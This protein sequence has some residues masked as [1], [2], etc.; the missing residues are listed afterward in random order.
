MT[1]DQTARMLSRIVRQE[2][3]WKWNGAHTGAAYAAFCVSGRT[4]GAHR[5]VYEYY[6]APIPAGLHLDHLCRNRWCVNPTHLE[7]VTSGENTRRSPLMGKQQRGHRPGG[8]NGNGLK[9]ECVRGHRFTPE[10][11]IARRNGGRWCRQCEQIRSSRRNR[12]QASALELLDRMIAV[13]H[14]TLSQN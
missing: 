7:P 9:Q 3:C 2:G 8:N 13:G 12:R 1:A 14:S 4:L 10:N 11:T 5:V 6:V